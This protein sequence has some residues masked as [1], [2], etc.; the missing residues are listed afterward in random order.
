MY[1]VP[2]LLA[3]YTRRRALLWSPSL[4]PGIAALIVF[5]LHIGAVMPALKTE[6]LVNRLLDVVAL[7]MT[8]GVLHVWMRSL[9]V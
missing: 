5:R 1:A 7:L 3:A 8:A 4:V 6:A 2:L 9:E